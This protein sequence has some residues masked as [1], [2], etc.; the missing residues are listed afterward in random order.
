[1]RTLVALLVVLALA[2]CRDGAEAP[3]PPVGAAA[4]AAMGASCV[5]GG[6]QLVERGASR[7][8]ICVQTMPD[9]GRSC[10][11]ATDCR[12]VCLARSRTCAPVDPLFGCQ[13]V[14]LSDGRQV[15]QCLD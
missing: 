2:A 9:A 14:L 1:M 12:G 3:L 8:L 13:E 7:A 11:R 10:S 4:D 15:T 5:R 6:G